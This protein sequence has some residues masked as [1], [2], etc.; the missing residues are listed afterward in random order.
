MSRCVKCGKELSVD[1]IA[2]YKKLVNRAATE[3]MCV[4]CLADYFSVSVELLEEKKK[5]FKAQGCTLFA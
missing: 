2:L 1:D 3:F 5:Q 4:D